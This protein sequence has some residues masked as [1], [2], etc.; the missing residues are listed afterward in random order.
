MHEPVAGETVPV[1]HAC[2]HDMH[3]VC[4]MAVATLL[5]NARAEWNGTLTC[6]FQLNEE[7]GAGAQAMVDG[8]LQS[9]TDP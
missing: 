3:V 4:M 8:A 9:R 1:M 6:L 7:G 2:G 5:K